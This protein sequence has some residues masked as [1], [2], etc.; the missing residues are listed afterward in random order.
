MSM[1]QLHV[2]VRGR[3]QGVFFRASTQREARRLG[4]TGWVKN[5]SD[6]AVEMLAEGEETSL[7]QL[8][9][10]AERGPSA[11]RVDDVQVRW[12]SYVGDFPDFSD[13]GLRC[14]CRSPVSSSLCSAPRRR[15]PVPRPPRRRCPPPRP[16][17]RSRPPRST[18]PSPSSPTRRLPCASAPRR[19]SRRRPPRPSP[20][21]RRGCS[22]RAAARGRC[23]SCSTRRRSPCPQAA[24]T[25]PTSSSRSSPR[26][27]RR[28]T[29]RSR[30]CSPG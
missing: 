22:S 25:T 18:G 17:P 14:P 2:L 24:P 3:V 10:W 27:T 29:A 12:R 1:K 16:R 6:G 9:L 30:S 8:Q 7:K 11:A 19:R 28:R 23:G 13:H 26:A 21:W 4:L 20:R 5:R 15:S